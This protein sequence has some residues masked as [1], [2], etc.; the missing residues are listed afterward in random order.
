LGFKTTASGTFTFTLNQA[1]GLF[2]NNSTIFIKDNVLELEHNITETP[3]EFV[4][5]AGEF[6]D[7]FEL[8]YQETLSIQNPIA[9]ANAF[10]VYKEGNGIQLK[11]I[12]QEITSVTVY[13]ISG[14]MIASQ[15]NSSTE[16]YIPLQ[17]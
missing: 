3:Y 12:Q 11:S 6:N 4:S 10:I 9:S 15:Q 7:R 14:R 8:V 2:E 17:N 1:D 13:D 16:I 5:E